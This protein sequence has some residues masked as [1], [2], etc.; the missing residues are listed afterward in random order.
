MDGLGV[1][2]QMQVKFEM[3]ATSGPGVSQCVCAH[4]RACVC[5][6][7][8]EGGKR[9]WEGWGPG[10]CARAEPLCGARPRHTRPRVL[11]HLAPKQPSRRGG[12]PLLFHRRKQ[13]P[14]EAF[15]PEIRA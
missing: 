5:V 12:E 1:S 11:P 13:G 15:A 9:A 2:Q 7:V 6:R 4:A 10:A 8:S 3:S 14:Q